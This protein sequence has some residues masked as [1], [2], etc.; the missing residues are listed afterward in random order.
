MKRTSIRT[1][2]GFTLVEVMVVIVVM[3]IMASLVLLNL[4]GTDHRKALQAKE[5]FILDLE[6]ILREANDQSR[7][8]A[9]D[10]QAATDVTAF[11]YA[12]M[13]Y[14]PQQTSNLTNNS[15]WQPYS[16]FKIRNLPEQVSFQ[17]TATDYQFQNAANTTLLQNNAPQLIFLGNGDVKPVRV[18]FYF[19][20]RALGAEIDIDHLGKINAE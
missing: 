10:I 4:N 2:Y 14:Q 7:V 1:Q 16:E 6:R 13:E 11:R 15:P 18:Q 20:D 8:L 17:V 9:L 12:V 3:G 19:E 5:L